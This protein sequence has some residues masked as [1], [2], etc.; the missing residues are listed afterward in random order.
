LPYWDLLA[1]LRPAH[2]ISHWATTWPGFGRPDVTAATMRAAHRAFVEQ[3]FAAL[4][5]S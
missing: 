5:S 1:T 2:Y 4:R 3:A